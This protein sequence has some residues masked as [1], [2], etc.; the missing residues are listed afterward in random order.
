MR[1]VVQGKDPD[2]N[3]L[4]SLISSSGLRFTA[5]REGASND[6]A[7]VLFE[8]IRQ[9]AQ[10]VGFFVQLPRSSAE[11]RGGLILWVAVVGD[12]GDQLVELDAQVNLGRRAVRGGRVTAGDVP[13]LALVVNHG[14][15]SKS[16]PHHGPTAWT[17][18]VST[19]CRRRRCCAARKAAERVAKEGGNL[20]PGKPLDG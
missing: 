17:I 19:A 16:L 9:R 7:G 20:Q 1:Q 15:S 18:R 8:K 2:G 10:P 4:W 6:A 12:G 11:L 14:S 5:C 13:Q 3:A